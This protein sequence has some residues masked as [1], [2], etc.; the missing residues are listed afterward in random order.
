[1]GRRMKEAS[2][3]HGRCSYRLRSSLLPSLFVMLLV[4]TMKVAVVV[5][6]WSDLISSS[7]R[8]QTALMAYQ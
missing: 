8:G 7:D 3:P 4:E 2:R 6:G 1:M 5:A